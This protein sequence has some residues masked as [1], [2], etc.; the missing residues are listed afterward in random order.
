MSVNENKPDPPWRMTEEQRELLPNITGNEINGLGEAQQ[1]RPDIVYWPN[2]SLR[3]GG[4][5]DACQCNY[6]NGDFAKIAGS[7]D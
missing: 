3:S 7:Y 5:L 4:R 2:D 1:R 6:Q